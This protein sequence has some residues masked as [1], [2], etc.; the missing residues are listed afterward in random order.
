MKIPVL[1]LVAA[2][3]SPATGADE[4]FLK[5]GGQLSGRIVT[6]TA[7]K[8]EI[9]IGAGRVTVPAS[10]VVRIEEGRSALQDYEERAQHIA[11]GDAVG[12]VALGDWASSKGLGTQAREAY[13]RA[14]AVSP[15]DP[16]ANAALG[17]VEVG[18]RW[19]TEDEGYRARGYVQFE[20]E[21]MTPAEHDA[22]LRERAAADEQERQAQE[23]DQRA[24]DAEQ[25]AAEAEERARQADE[26]A[27]QAATDGPLLPLYYG[28]GAGPA[29]WPDAAGRL[30]SDSQPARR[31]ASPGAAVSAVKLRSAL[32]LVA[33]LAAGPAR[34]QTVDE[35]VARHVA[36]RGGQ[37]A[38]AAVRTLRMT[39]HAVAGPGRE[40]I[41]RRE[42]ARPGRIRTEFVFQGTT[43]VY[44]W[45]G[46]TGS[47]VS[48]LDG[49][50]EPEPLSEDAAALSAEQ[51]DL[52]GP[53]VNWKEKGHRVELV[54]GASLPGGAA[55]ELKVTLQSGAVRRVW[56][57]ANTGQIVKTSST[58]KVRGHELEFETVYADYRD[59]AGIRFARS[60]EIAVRGRP[61]RMRIGVES[62]EVNP[63]LEDSRFRMPR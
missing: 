49:G 24:R 36:A 16:R 37:K 20:G 55:H 1:V 58:R 23:A 63:T 5:S 51:A 41:V 27:A 34:A 15:N 54:G 53:L 13:N 25:R 21:W 60:I 8:V 18:G 6:R 32:A 11:P 61:Q 38:L 47:R 30:A 40:A 29:Y 52:E 2:L 46:S 26:A 9:D 19:V 28:W 56:V 22:I 3:L 14:L 35:I 48:P 50:F 31:A 43:G 42:I 33:V 45:D 7:D 59:T 57:D 17:N 12:W 62:V 10:S 4:I 39:G 44:V